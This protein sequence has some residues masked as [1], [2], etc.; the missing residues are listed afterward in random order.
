[1][2]EQVAIYRDAGLDGVVA[3]PIDVDA[4]MRQIGGYMP[5]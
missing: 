4:L 2:P 3:K 1:M 5:A